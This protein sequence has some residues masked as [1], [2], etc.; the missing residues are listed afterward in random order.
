MQRLRFSVFGFRFS[1][2]PGP[3]RE[4]VIGKLDCLNIVG[5]KRPGFLL[6]LLG[7]L[8]GSSVFGED[9]ATTDFPPL[10]TEYRKPKTE[11]QS[12][13]ALL[14]RLGVPEWHAQGW[15]GQGLKV[16]V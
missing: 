9:D 7:A 14:E 2:H 5:W 4:V 1:A 12:R 10:T 3:G 16:A 15:K 13:E 6:L 11:N 8:C